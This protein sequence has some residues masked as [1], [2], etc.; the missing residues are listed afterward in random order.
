[1]HFYRLASHQPIAERFLAICCALHPFVSHLPFPAETFEPWVTY[2]NRLVVFLFADIGSFESV[3]D[4]Y[5]H[6]SAIEDEPF[7]MLCGNNKCIRLSHID[8]ER[9]RHRSAA[10]RSKSKD[11][12]VSASVSASLSEND[13]SEMT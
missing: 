11:E 1:M 6:T 4:F 5:R 2:A 13:M 9:K 7:E 10:A 12:V 3:D 8:F